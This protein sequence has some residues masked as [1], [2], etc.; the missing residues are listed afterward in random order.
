MM[1]VAFLARR[2]SP[3]RWQAEQVAEALDGVVEELLAAVHHVVQL[4][5]HLEAD[6]SE[7]RRP[8][9]DDPG[10]ERSPRDRA[11]SHRLPSARS[12]GRVRPA[13]SRIDDPAATPSATIRLSTAPTR[14]AGPIVAGGAA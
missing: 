2:V 4:A 8:D 1:K 9:L 6:Q 7:Q 11:E 14:A 5:E 3:P 13:R 10:A 12:Q